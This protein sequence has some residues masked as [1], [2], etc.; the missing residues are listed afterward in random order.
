VDHFI[1]ILTNHRSRI[2]ISTNKL[3]ELQND[4]TRKAYAKVGTDLVV[5]CLG[6]ITG[7]IDSFETSFSQDI[8]EA[9]TRFLTAL[10]TTSTTDQD[11]A[12]QSL[13]FSLF[14]QKRCGEE[15]KYTVLAFSFIVLYSF[16]EEGMLQPCNTISQH[17]SKVVFFARAAIFNRIRSDAK[18]EH[19]GFFE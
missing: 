9:G 18:Q 15:S 1:R 5:F 16:T 8:A 12:L 10:Q 6:I 17:F 19:K 3:K 2:G 7:E 11:D 14:S 4:K 13:L